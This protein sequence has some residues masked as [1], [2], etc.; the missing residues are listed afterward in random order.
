[1]PNQ[2]LKC[3]LATQKFRY[4]ENERL[5]ISSRFK[6]DFIGYTLSFLPTSHKET[7]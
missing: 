5:N 4:F 2:I 6:K 1:M 7:I 3:K